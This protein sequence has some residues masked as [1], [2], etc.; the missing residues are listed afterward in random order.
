MIVFDP[1]GVTVNS[2]GREALERSDQTPEPQRG[3]RGASLS[4]RWGSGVPICYQGLTPLAINFR[5][6]GA[7]SRVRHSRT[8]FL[9]VGVK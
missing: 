1:N 9:S 5:P 7:A 2:Q 3:D 6:F 8:Y 4:P